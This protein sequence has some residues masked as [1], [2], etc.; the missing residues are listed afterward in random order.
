[1]ASITRQ[2][3]GRKT[4]QFVGADGR[5]RSVRLGKATMRTAEAVKV[6]VEHLVAASI[7]GHSLDAETLRWLAGLDSQLYDR[8]VA[9]GLV[10]R[11]ESATQN[12]LRTFCD[13]Y[14]KSR[15]DASARTRHNLQIAAD[16]LAKF[17][18][19]DRELP[20]IT[21]GEAKDWERWLA[22]EGGRKGGPLSMNSVRGYVKKVKQLFNAAID[23]K[24]ID[25]NPF[26]KLVGSIVANKERQFFVT[27]EMSQRVL[28]FCPDAEWRLL[29][30]FCRWAGLRNPSETLNMRW[31]YIDWERN[32]MAVRSPKTDAHGI[33]FRDVPIFP[34]LR[35]HLEAAF[36][37]AEV[38]AE[39]CIMQYRSQDKNMRTRFQKIVRRAGYEPW[40]RLFQNLRATRETELMEEFPAHVACDWIGNST[41]VAMEHYAQTTDAHFEKA[42]QKAVQYGAERDRETLH[43]SA[44]QDRKT[45]EN[46]TFPQTRKGSEY[47]REDSN[48]Q[49][50]AP[51]ASGQSAER[52]SR[53][54]VV[55]DANRVVLSVVL[56]CFLVLI[57]VRSDAGTTPSEAIRLGKTC[58][59]RGS[60]RQRRFRRSGRRMSCVG[61]GW[62]G[63]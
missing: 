46:S 16:S 33:R 38:G 62:V 8:L 7:S 42:V 1:M 48:L 21:A 49:P 22:Q 51:E 5:R 26:K 37:L 13:T 29:F 41:A 56:F 34:E 53:H 28:E 11:R 36:E 60:R 25:S 10:A 19:P 30:A 24:L 50:L 6:R 2:K 14:I 17:F 35:P 39:F 27:P 12:S 44:A 3:N 63:C 23:Y 9:V 15:T 45:C 57:L 20:T 55:A 40:P 18:G 54:R 59:R 43:S 52:S 61:H 32:R 31:E 47:P 58:R 4:I